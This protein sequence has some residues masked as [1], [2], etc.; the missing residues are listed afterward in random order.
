MPFNQLNLQTGLGYWD[1]LHARFWQA[2]RHARNIMN[3]KREF[4]TLVYT[5]CI[6]FKIYKLIKGN[7]REIF[8][9][10]LR[11]L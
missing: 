1:D 5:Q 4:V 9:I 2:E 6:K 8:S 10:R 3:V 11:N 7:I